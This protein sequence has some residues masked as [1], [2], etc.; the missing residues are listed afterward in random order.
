[1]NQPD[2]KGRLL[3]FVVLVLIAALAASVTFHWF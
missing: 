3:D 2:G 1:M